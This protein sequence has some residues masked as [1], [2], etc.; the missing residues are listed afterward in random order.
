MS[1]P[2]IVWALKVAPV[3][4]PTQALVL[5]AL[6]ETAKPDGTEAR[7]AQATY[8]NWARSSERTLRR[9]LRALEMAGLIRRGDQSLVAHLR[10]D[11]RP[12][13]WDLALEV[14]SVSDLRPDTG[15][16]PDMDDRG[17]TDDPPYTPR[18][19]VGDLSSTERP[20]TGGPS[21]AERPDTHGQNGRTLLS[22]KPS[23]EP[24]LR[25]EPSI[26]SGP[27]QEVIEVE[28]V[29][30]EPFVAV[31]PAP[32]RDDVEKCCQLLAD[33]IEQNGSR[34]PT[35]TQ[36]WRDAARL[37][38]DR[39]KIAFES[40]MG[41]ITWSQG[42]DFWRINILSM[43]TLRKQYDRLR[44]QAESEAKPRQS[45]TDRKVQQTM[46]LAARLRAEGR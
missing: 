23:T 10:P 29:D 33:L 32:S 18:P 24:S 11:R 15:D 1:I 35:V 31:A 19:V 45:T 36:G 3:S 34:R 46:D 2:A 7:A 27:V 5:V 22:D 28:V 25:N 8:A 26:N 12:V 17:D 42:H 6:A 9:H 14:T 38:I 16:R 40:V 44:L 21:L 39:D 13:V 37:M 43:P 4:D 20:V 41:A 30:A